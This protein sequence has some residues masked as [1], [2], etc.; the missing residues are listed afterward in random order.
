M[1]RAI[2]CLMALWVTLIASPLW[3]DPIANLSA[4]APTQYVD[5]TAIPGTATITYR[6]YCGTTSGTYNY[7]Y[8]APNLD[9]GTSIDVASCVQGQPGTYYFVATAESSEYPGAESAWSNEATR[10]WTAS[11]LGKV[12]NAPTLF[13]IQ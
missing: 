6:V 3:A 2:L 8:N 12:P 5:G 4:T 10:T 9:P 11:D 13:T 1:K 7:M